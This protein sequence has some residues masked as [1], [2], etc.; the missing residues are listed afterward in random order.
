MVKDSIK[1]LREPIA[2]IL[3]SAVAVDFIVGLWHLLE[4]PDSEYAQES[5]FLDN[6]YY[7]TSSF[8]GMTFAVTLV[9][10]LLVVTVLPDKLPRAKPIVLVVAIESG[11][12]LLF[13]IL[14][15]FL[16]LFY[17]EESSVSGTSIGPDGVD[18]AQSFI[19]NL[20]ALALTLIP[21]LLAL[22]MVKSADLFGGLRPPQQPGGGYYGVPPQQPYQGQPYPQQPQGFP[23]QQQGFPP[24]QQQG[25]PGSFPGWGA[26]P[27]Q[28]GG[29]GQGW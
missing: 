1:S 5:W 15:M 25:Y 24:Q 19:G 23:P 21:L 4:K 11:V 27:Q 7:G 12:L 14:T 2:W 16:G 10:A 29:Y 28:G 6:A 18:K 26:P 20:S 22:A 3:V 9:A 8:V 13:G 17:Q